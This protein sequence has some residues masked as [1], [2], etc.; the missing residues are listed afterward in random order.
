MIIGFN[1]FSMKCEDLTDG[2]QDSLPFMV[3]ALCG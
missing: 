1:S 2:K 3:E